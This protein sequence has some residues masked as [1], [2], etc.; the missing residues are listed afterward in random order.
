[1]GQGSSLA[2]GSDSKVIRSVDARQRHCQTKREA[3][4]GRRRTLARAES[5]HG[6]SDA[7]TRGLSKVKHSCSSAKTQRH[8][9]RGAGAAFRKVRRYAAAAVRWTL[10]SSSPVSEKSA[11]K[12]KNVEVRTVGTSAVL[13]AQA[14]RQI[15]LLRLGICP[16]PEAHRIA[17]HQVA[18]IRRAP[19]KDSLQS[20]SD[21]RSSSASDDAQPERDDPSLGRASGNFRNVFLRKLSYEGVWLPPAQ[22]P[23]RHNT[24]IV[25]DWDDTLLCTSF[26]SQRR[27]LSSFSSPVLQ[28]RLSGVAAAGRRLLELARGLGETLVVTNAMDDW[29]EHSAKKYLPSLLPALEGVEVISARQR[30]E[31]QFPQQVAEWKRQAFL[32]VR[33][34]RNLE[35]VTNFIAIGDSV[36]EMDAAMAVGEVF[37]NAIVKT[38]KFRADP[39]PEELTK[40]LDLACQRLAYIVESGRDLQ[41]AIERKSSSPA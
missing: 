22:Q 38:V 30:Y 5:P 34:Q 35:C 1:M 28:D 3:S 19:T 15:Y 23:K 25:F 37:P 41:V 21:E 7:G 24:L 29:V 18:S 2:E 10:E 8:K 13:T 11:E 26:L 36:F 12:A 16:E 6:D 31:A 40:E 17:G 32:D 9:T 39:S 27:G 20:A 33:R 4:A 14:A